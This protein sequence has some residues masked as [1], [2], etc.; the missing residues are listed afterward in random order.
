MRSKKQLTT[1]MLLTALLANT[2]LA[3][4]T[5]EPNVF[6]AD[7]SHPD[8][9]AAISAF[10]QVCMPFVLH[11]TELTQKQNG[12]HHAKLMESRGFAF[13]SSEIRSRR[14]RIKPYGERKPTTRSVKSGTFTVF[15]GAVHPSGELNMRALTPANYITLSTQHLKYSL[16]DDSRL[17]ANINWNYPSQ[18]HPG[19]SCEIRL[20]QPKIEIASFAVDFIEKD[21]DW[22]LKNN[23]WT[24]CIT[25]GEDQ[26][27]FEVSRTPQTLAISMIRNDFY[28]PNICGGKG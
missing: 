11:E 7:T 10:E 26:F 27:R 14:V 24:Q 5:N 16:R 23:G 19:K 13:Q 28:K 22:L 18:N 2:A 12:Q 17:T 1:C 15:N 20:D 21:A 3:A 25:E 4:D 6:N 9:A 8:L